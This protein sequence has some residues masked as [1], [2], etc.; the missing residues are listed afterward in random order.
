[1]DVVTWILLF[2]LGVAGCGA[3]APAG[4]ADSPPTC[5]DDA[6]FVDR[7]DQDRAV[8]VRRGSPPRIVPRAAL[9]GASEG[10]ALGDAACGPSVRAFVSRQRSRQ[11]KDMRYPLRL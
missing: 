10:D 9:E 8:L 1:M 2:L 5:L 7:I 11:A 6:W 4:P 3:S